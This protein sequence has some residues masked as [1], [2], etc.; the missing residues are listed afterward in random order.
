MSQPD[1]TAALALSGPDAT[2]K[3]Y[4]DWAESYDGGFARGMEYLLPDHVA[5][6]FLAAGGEGPVLDVGAGTGLCA[7]G[8]RAGGLA[9][10][11]DALDVSAEMLAQAAGKGLYRALIRADVTRSLPLPRTYRGVVSSGTFTAGHVGPDAFGPLLDV[12]LPGA[13]F[14]LSVNLRVWAQGF[15]DALAR[16]E[17]EGRIAARQ[18]L[19]V[20]VY[21]QAAAA[22][23]PAHAGD[24]ALIVMFRAA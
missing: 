5:R 24:R 15:E 16:L 12:A 22:L 3:L 2:L 10:E 21:G 23:D 7:A 17:A 8:L 13:L 18:T 6:A 11:V 20:A 1:L 9:A 4:R 14:A 19:E